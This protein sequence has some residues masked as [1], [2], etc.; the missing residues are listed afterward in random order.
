MLV[1]RVPSAFDSFG[2]ARH[3]AAGR[4]QLGGALATADE[5]GLDDSFVSAAIGDI[6]KSG[7]FV[8]EV[9]ADEPAV[10]EKDN[11]SPTTFSAAVPFFEDYL[12][13]R[14]VSF[15]AARGDYIVCLYCSAAW[16]ARTHWFPGTYSGGRIGLIE[17]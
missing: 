8:V 6:P 4:N 14:R 13:P 9:P 11:V 16:N 5:V 2:A 12:L 15:T 17:R 3:A 1:I 7:R 10:E